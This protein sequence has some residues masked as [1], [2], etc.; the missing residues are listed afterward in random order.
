[1][2]QKIEMYPHRNRRSLCYG[3]LSTLSLSTFHR[4]DLEVES[5]VLRRVSVSNLYNDAAQWRYIVYA[6]V[7]SKLNLLQVFPL[8]CPSDTH[9]AVLRFNAA[10][11]EGYERDVGN[12]TT[13]RIINSQVKCK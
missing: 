3:D 9:E 1:M 13:I 10:P 2:Q 4:C 7:V 8:M 11:T 6:S 5:L 12:K